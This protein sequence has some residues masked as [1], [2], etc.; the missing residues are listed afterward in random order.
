VPAGPVRPAASSKRGPRILNARAAATGRSAG[1]A[2]RR[3]RSRTAHH[4]WTAAA[5]SVGP[6]PH[7][8]GR[9]GRQDQLVAQWCEVLAEHAAEVRLGRA[10]GRAVVVGDVDVGDAEVECPPQDRPLVRRGP[11]LTGPQQRRSQRSA[12]AG[13]PVTAA[14]TSPAT[15]PRPRTPTRSIARVGVRWIYPARQDRRP[16]RQREPQQS[17]SPP[18][19]RQRL[20]YDHRRLT[21]PLIR[22]GGRRSQQP[23][24]LR[25]EA[26]SAGHAP[27]REVPAWE[28]AGGTCR[29]FP[30]QRP[31]RT[32]RSRG[33]EP[34]PGR[35]RS[36]G[37]PV[38]VPGT[39]AGAGLQ[40]QGAGVG[41]AATP[42]ESTWSSLDRHRR[43]GAQVACAPLCGLRGTHGDTST[44]IPTEQGRVGHRHLLSVKTGLGEV[45]R[46][47]ECGRRGQVKEVEKVVGGGVASSER[48]QIPL[49]FDRLEDR[50]VVVDDM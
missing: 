30:S 15:T 48:R 34:R 6:G 20:P 11:Q 21:R 45:G 33:W 35:V 41:A 24:Q 25:A 31:A 5:L 22:G 19:P 1:Y 42:A 14:A 50:G 13:V 43:L 40:G 16:L 44:R 29:R 36:G 46:D 37:C 27:G 12:A 4:G 7:V 38:T 2:G 10:V 49:P 9:L 47:E 26:A 28:H 3:R 17:R 23:E 8:V 18:V 39:A 32:V